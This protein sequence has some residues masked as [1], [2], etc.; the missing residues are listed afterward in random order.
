MK[1]LFRAVGAAVITVGMLLYVCWIVV[2]AH[3][4]D[5]N[6]TYPPKDFKMVVDPRVQNYIFEFVVDAHIRDVEVVPQLQENIAMIIA[7]D[8]LK[9]PMLGLYIREP[10]CIYLSEYILADK[11]IAR[12]VIYHELGHAL[13]K[14]Q[15]HPCE[16]CGDVMAAR[17]PESFYIY[18]DPE[19]WEE[20][21]DGL[22]EYI[23]NNR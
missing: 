13:T 19:V 16:N 10:K 22:F 7:V 23:K 1:D 18:A 12:R 15:E 21:V 3:T 11:L 14:Q 6:Y 5:K 2:L 4:S 17:T 8:Y 9:Y 20:Q